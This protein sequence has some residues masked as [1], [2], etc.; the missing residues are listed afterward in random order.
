M[1][2]YDVGIALPLLHLLQHTLTSLL[3]LVLPGVLMFFQLLLEALLLLLR[4]L[5]L[6]FRVVLF[7]VA[8]FRVVLFRVVLFRVVLFRVVLLMLR[9]DNMLL[10]I[11]SSLL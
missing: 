11:L 8:L 4:L 9:S 10:S 7:R 6:L 3:V 2:Y 5:L 1:F